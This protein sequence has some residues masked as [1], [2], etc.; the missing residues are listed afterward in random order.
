MNYPEIIICEEETIKLKELK[1]DVKE[2]YRELDPD[3]SLFREEYEISDIISDFEKLNDTLV[4]SEY[5]AFCN[6]NYSILEEEE[7]NIQAIIHFYYRFMKNFQ[8]KWPN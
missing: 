7:L 1:T 6:E 3:Q 2:K 5:E 4:K 8:Q